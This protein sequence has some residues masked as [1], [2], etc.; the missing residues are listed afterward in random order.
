MLKRR[1]LTRKP[2]TYSTDPDETGVVTAVVPPSFPIEKKGFISGLI[3]P[4]FK[5]GVNVVDI[6]A[7]DYD[8]TC[9][10]GGIGNN[11]IIRENFL[12]PSVNPRTAYDFEL[13]DQIKRQQEG[14]TVK[15]GD[16]T[17]Q[18]MFRIVTVDPT[19]T[20]WLNEYQRRLAN[21]ESKEA[22]AIDPPF[23]RKQRPLTKNVNFGEASTQSGLDINEKLDL[24]RQT[25]INGPAYNQPQAIADIMLLLDDYNKLSR[26]NLETMQKVLIKT[27]TITAP[28][29]YFGLA[30]YHRY[31]SIDQ[32]NLSRSKIL[33]YLLVNNK[34]KD[35]KRPIFYNGNYINFTQATDLMSYQYEVFDSSG[36]RL[37]NGNQNYLDIETLQVVDRDFVVKAVNAGE[38]A[39]AINNEYPPPDKVTGVR[40]WLTTIEQEDAVELKRRRDNTP[41]NR[42]LPQLP[43]AVPVNP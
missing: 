42:P 31:W 32:V 9:K 5:A 14:T 6:K 40:R 1:G 3:R 33:M 25:V 11:L 7:K 35:Q 21:G 8:I 22:L 37:P 12:A 20:L 38:D 36:N 15:F 4:N 27:G 10:R 2:F 16:K 43:I 23:G 13:Q 41:P 29:I 18:D 28:K 17:L 19:D 26:E 34:S 39:G 24:I 30:G